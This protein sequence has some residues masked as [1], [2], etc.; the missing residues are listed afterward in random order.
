MRAFTSPDALGTTYHQHVLTD[1]TD[2]D[3]I[4]AYLHTHTDIDLVVFGGETGLVHGSADVLTEAMHRLHRPFA[5]FA[6]S[7]AAS[8]IEGCKRFSKQLMRELGIPTPACT[9]CDT[10]RDA[11]VCVLY[12]RRTTR[13]SCVLLRRR[14]RW[15]PRTTSTC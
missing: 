15:A 12:T 13:R 7:R 4:L 3:A 2:T 5:C 11:L 14:T 1:D 10:P 6:P 9:V 8:R